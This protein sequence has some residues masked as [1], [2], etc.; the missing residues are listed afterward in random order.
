MGE[1]DYL[2]EILTPKKLE[3]TLKFEDFDFELDKICNKYDNGCDREINT[4]LEKEI[5]E[6]W[7][8]PKFEGSEKSEN[9]TKKMRKYISKPPKFTPKLKQVLSRHKIR[10][11]QMKQIKEKI[12]KLEKEYL[13][14]E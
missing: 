2:N 9:L 1:E 8:L 10:Y 12:K 4:L 13:A 7:D 6:E 11:A 3:F 5:F 14:N